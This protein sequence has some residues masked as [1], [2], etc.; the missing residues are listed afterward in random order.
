M[1]VAHTRLAGFAECALDEG[2]YF[3]TVPRNAE[4]ERRMMQEEVRQAWEDRAIAAQS[5]IWEELEPQ[6]AC[7]SYEL[8]IAQRLLSKAQD[9][10]ARDCQTQVTSGCWSV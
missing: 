7:R 5:K 1:P 10:A 2:R 6:L 3:V 4:E 8:E 9:E